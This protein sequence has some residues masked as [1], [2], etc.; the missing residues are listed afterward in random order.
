MIDVSTLVMDQVRE[1]LSE[2]GTIMILTDPSGVI[3]KTEGDPATLEAAGNTVSRAGS[4]PRAS[5]AP[6]PCSMGLPLA[7]RHSPGLSRTRSSRCSRSGDG[8]GSVTALEI[9]SPLTDH[10]DLAVGGTKRTSFHAFPPSASLRLPRL[11]KA[12]GFQLSVVRRP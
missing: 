7:S 8:S 3:L 1:S 12:A 9:P 6:I 4:M 5:V 11:R 2:S 10:R